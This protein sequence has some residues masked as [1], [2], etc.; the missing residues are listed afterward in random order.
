MKTSNNYYKTKRKK[1]YETDM[2]FIAIGILGL[3]FILFLVSIY[4]S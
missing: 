1:Q 4:L 2:A 3:G